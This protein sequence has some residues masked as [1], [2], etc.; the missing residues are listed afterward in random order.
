MDACA[1]AM[2]N[3]M[4][5]PKLKTGTAF[6]IALSFGAFQAGMPVIGFV[7]GDRFAEAISDI[8]H[9]IALILLVWIGGKMIWDAFHEEDDFEAKCD[10]APKSLLAQS[11]ATSIDALAVGVGLAATQV[12]ILPAISLIGIV[13]FALSLLSIYVGKWTC[14]KLTGK[15]QLAGGI[16]LIIIGI[17][18]FIEHTTHVI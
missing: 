5:I 14:G 13:T 6:L 17:K 12:K 1:V 10:L 16:I 4:C 3:G 8:D 7:V 2:V 9:W 15:A 11:V 18:I